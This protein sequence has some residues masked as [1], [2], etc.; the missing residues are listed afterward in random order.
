MLFR[1]RK[2]ENRFIRGTIWDESLYEKDIVLCSVTSEG[3]LP[4]DLKAT[5]KLIE[6]LVKIKLHDRP[7]GYRTVKFLLDTGASS[8]FI[9]KQLVEKERITCYPDRKVRITTADGTVSSSSHRTEPLKF[10]IGT[11]YC[12]TQSFIPMKLS[13]YAGILGM[14]FINA[15]HIS[16]TGGFPTEVTAPYKGKVISLPVR[17]Y[18]DHRN[19]I[20]EKVSFLHSEKEV[21]RELYDPENEKCFLLAPVQY[22]NRTVDQDHIV[23]ESVPQEIED[24]VK[25]VP[26]QYQ[27]ILKGLLEQFKTLFPADLP[28]DTLPD[29]PIEHA[30]VTDP[31]QDRKSVV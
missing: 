13:G 7:E 25:E 11:Q 10:R 23:M 20:S 29:H 9:S 3:K 8:N 16:I 24:K 5:T 28:I 2:R 1:S 6:F 31:T 19:R 12:A 27:G 18:Q 30:I 4:Q 15:N 17:M 26:A 21:K 14:P 22:K